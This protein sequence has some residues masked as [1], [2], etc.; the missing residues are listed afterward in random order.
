MPKSKNVNFTARARKDFESLDV[1]TQKRVADAIR[2]IADE[3]LLGKKLKG[4]LS[5][6]RSYRRGPYRI[7][8]SFTLQ[9]LDIVVI[10]HRKDVYR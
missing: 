9:S 4:E 1:V 5:A 10:E 8:Y 3:P 2:T 6:Y 7:I